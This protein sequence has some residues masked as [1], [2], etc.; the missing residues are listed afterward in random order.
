MLF[1]GGNISDC[2]C[3]LMLESS[4]SGSWRLQNLQNN[5]QP[6]EILVQ[7][8]RLCIGKNGWFSSVNMDATNII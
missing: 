7:M 3:L 6:S 8:P 1:K 4:L 5:T 2:I